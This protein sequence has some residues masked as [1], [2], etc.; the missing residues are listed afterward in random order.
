MIRINQNKIKKKKIRK[1]YKER[2][3]GRGREREKDRKILDQASL[4][5]SERNVN[6]ILLVPFT[7]S[8]LYAVNT[9]LGF[10]LKPERASERVILA[11]FKFKG[12]STIFTTYYY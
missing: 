1:K 11:V 6:A 7:H 5:T 4:N 2:E 10:K 12:Q 8:W 3:R 9:Q